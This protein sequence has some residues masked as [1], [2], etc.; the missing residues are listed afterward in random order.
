MTAQANDKRVGTIDPAGRHLEEEAVNT[1]CVGSP[2]VINLNRMPPFDVQ[3]VACTSRCDQTRRRQ[4]NKL[5]LAMSSERRFTARLLISD[6]FAI[7][8]R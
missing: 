6:H 8:E 4:T 2:R 3:N 7:E 1:R 5:F